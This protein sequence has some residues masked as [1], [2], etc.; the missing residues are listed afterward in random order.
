[1]DN[2]YGSVR[3]G[4]LGFIVCGALCLDHGDHFIDIGSGCGMIPNA[5]GLYLP[6]VSCEGIELDRCHLNVAQQTSD[7]LEECHESLCSFS[8]PQFLEGDFRNK[9]FMK[10]LLSQP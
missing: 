9:L 5:I 3:F 2:F 1:M 4:L 7:M 10:E 8:P 6:F